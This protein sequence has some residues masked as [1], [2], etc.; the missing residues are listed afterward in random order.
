ME[1]DVV[2][3]DVEGIELEVLG[4]REVHISQQAIGCGLLHVFVEFAQEPFD[5]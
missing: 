4:G 1:V 2:G 3:E 5:P